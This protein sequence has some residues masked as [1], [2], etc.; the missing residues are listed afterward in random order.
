MSDLKRYSRSKNG[1]WIRAL[2]ETNEIGVYWHERYEAKGGQVRVIGPDDEVEREVPVQSADIGESWVKAGAI[3][4]GRELLEL[5]SLKSDFELLLTGIMRH[6]TQLIAQGWGRTPSE[7]V[8]WFRD[9]K[10]LEFLVVGKYDVHGPC[11]PPMEGL[12]GTVMEVSS[13]KNGLF[14]AEIVVT[15][16]SR[17]KVDLDDPKVIGAILIGSSPT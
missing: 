17:F 16:K 15:E 8:E 2:L 7:V 3:P 4:V 10:S 5:L 1:L 11:R 6:V 9:I 13:G 12:E 14:K